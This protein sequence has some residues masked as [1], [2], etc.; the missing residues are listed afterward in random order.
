MLEK[1]HDSEDERGKPVYI[2]ERCPKFKELMKQLNKEKKE[3][4]ERK[5]RVIKENK[6]FAEI[7]RPLI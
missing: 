5:T 4:E 6:R 3:A 2:K 7:G 1:D